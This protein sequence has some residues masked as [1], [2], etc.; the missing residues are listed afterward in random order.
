[1]SQGSSRVMHLSKESGDQLIMSVK[2]LIDPLVGKIEAMETDL[3]LTPRSGLN[4]LLFMNSHLNSQI[5]N[6]SDL[7]TCTH[8]PF[9]LD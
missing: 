2:D 7:N 8:G 9:E 6:Y 4:S 1:M 5:K 3:S